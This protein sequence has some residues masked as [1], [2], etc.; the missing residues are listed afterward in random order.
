VTQRRRRPPRR[1]RRARRRRP[2]GSSS[3]SR[4]SPTRRSRHRGVSVGYGEEVTRVPNAKTEE[5]HSWNRRVQFFIL[6]MDEDGVEVQHI[7]EARPTL[8]E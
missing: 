8:E 7:D 4:W 6:D 3:R 1:S 5:E 2:P